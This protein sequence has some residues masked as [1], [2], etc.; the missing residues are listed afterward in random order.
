M[1]QLT[2]RNRLAG[3]KACLKRAM[4]SWHTQPCQ[5]R[6]M[7]EPQGLKPNKQNVRL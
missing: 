3:L 4:P 2:V 1:A 7:D 6:D 5:H